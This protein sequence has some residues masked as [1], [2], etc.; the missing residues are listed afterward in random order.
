MT[1]RYSKEDPIK[2]RKLTLT[3]EQLHDLKCIF[4][5]DYVEGL[6]VNE[7]KDIAYENFINDMHD[8]VYNDVKQEIENTFN[9]AY[10]KDVIYQVMNNKAPPISDPW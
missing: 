7:L 2:R 1:Y 8:W 6:S 3:E 9:K 10:L 4:I 5:S